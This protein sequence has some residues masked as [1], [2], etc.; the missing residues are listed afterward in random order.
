MPKTTRTCTFMKIHHLDS[1]TSSSSCSLALHLS[2]HI[3]SVGHSRRCLMSKNVYYV[4]L[5]M[6]SVNIVH[7]NTFNE[8]KCLNIYVLN[9]VQGLNHGNTMMAYIGYIIYRLYSI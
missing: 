2:T 4:S 6:F 1:H 8:F 7:T 9:T 3:L 5:C